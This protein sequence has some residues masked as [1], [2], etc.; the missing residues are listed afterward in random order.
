MTSHRKPRTPR[1][2]ADPRIAYGPVP[3]RRLGRSVG[4]NI[5]PPKVCSYACSYCQVGP[6]HAK[7][8]DRREFYSPKEIA[9]TVE[10]LLINIERAGE[11][12]DFATFVAD[13]EPTLDI[14]LGGEIP[15][16]ASMGVKTALITNASLLWKADVAED[17]ARADRVSVKVDA[18]HP[19]TWRRLNRPHKDLDLPM[20]LDG[21]RAFAAQYD[22]RL[23][24]ET[25]LVRGVNDDPASIVNV[26]EFLREL[27]PETA[28]LAVPNRPP[29][30]DRALPPPDEAV[31]AAF[32]L[33]RSNDVNVEMLTGYEGDD[34]V[35]TGDPVEDLIAICAVHP[36][37][38]NAARRFLSS[39][40]VKA[41]ALERL[42]NDGLLKKSEFQ[43]IT[44]YRTQY[45]Q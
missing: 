31:R 9:D 28:Y 27:S 38:E 45:R 21:L 29:T 23:V 26:A 18:V 3:S 6:T 22:G 41:S 1:S 39:G 20:V 5:I 37:R 19:E 30:D 44:F 14:N 10:K 32:H 24:T 25:M 34:F 43:G 4:I 17:A 42:V 7:T 35:Q 33:F 8:I 16:I 12:I 40:G 13:G 15:T 11:S 36:M 2:S